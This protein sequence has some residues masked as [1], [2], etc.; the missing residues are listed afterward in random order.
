MVRARS[1]PG[2]AILNDPVMR[3]SLTQMQQDPRAITEYV[4]PTRSPTAAF[5]RAISRDADA[6]GFATPHFNRHMKNPVIAGKL[7][8][9]MDAGVIR[10]G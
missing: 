5:N 1:K 3:T 6:P 10:T 9:L 4:G 7:Q 8:K 2:Q